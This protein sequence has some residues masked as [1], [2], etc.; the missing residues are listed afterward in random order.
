[1]RADSSFQT[2]FWE[3]SVQTLGTLCFSYEDIL[4]FWSYRTSAYPQP[5]LS[6]RCA[7]AEN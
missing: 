3:V 2:A 7:R 1:M 5:V 4:R 6:K